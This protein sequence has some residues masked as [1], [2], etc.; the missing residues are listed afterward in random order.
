M[1]ITYTPVSGD[2]MSTLVYL[3]FL[4][5]S[6]NRVSDS[7]ALLVYKGYGWGSLSLVTNQAVSQKHQLCTGLD[8]YHSSFEEMV[9]QE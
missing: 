9:T 6:H 8:L 3:L 4:T 7:S 2:A 1:A 5:C